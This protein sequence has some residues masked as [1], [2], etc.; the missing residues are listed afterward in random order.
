MTS[1]NLNSAGGSDED[2]SADNVSYEMSH[3]VATAAAFANVNKKADDTAGGRSKGAA[4]SSK[5]MSGSI[6]E[7]SKVNDEGSE[8]FL[9]EDN[10]NLEK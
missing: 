1:N 5:I 10:I 8:F 2:Y 9:D 7:D 4:K 6:E 3:Q